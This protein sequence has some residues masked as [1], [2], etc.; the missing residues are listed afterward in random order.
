MHAAHGSQKECHP[1]VPADCHLTLPDF[2]KWGQIER[3][4]DERNP[5]KNCGKHDR[6]PG[7][8]LRGLPNMTKRILLNLKN[9]EKNLEAKL[10][11]QAEN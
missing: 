1:L 10:K 7:S 2:S 8:M 9:I 11:L 6:S 5:P 4:A 3:K